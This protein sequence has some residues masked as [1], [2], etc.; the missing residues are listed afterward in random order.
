M[1]P[2]NGTVNMM[3]WLFVSP[4]SRV[5][6][7]KR[8]RK[9]KLGATCAILIWALIIWALRRKLKWFKCLTEHK[10]SG[11]TAFAYEA[12]GKDGSSVCTS[13]AIPSQVIG[14]TMTSYTEALPYDI[15]TIFYFSSVHCT[16][17]LRMPYCTCCW[18]YAQ[19]KCITTCTWSV[20]ITQRHVMMIENTNWKTGFFLQLWN[21]SLVQDRVQCS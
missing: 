7:Q 1:Y 3:K 17:H 4:V 15:S 10:T 14:F 5:I 18:Y 20:F 6:I 13:L 2:V 9:T 16:H 19:Y 21:E 11:S 8:W 12:A